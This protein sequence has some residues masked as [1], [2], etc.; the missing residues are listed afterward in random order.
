MVE[1][2]L[3]LHLYRPHDTGS[4]SSIIARTIPSQNG[5]RSQA[6]DLSRMTQSDIFFKDLVPTA[7]E[8]NSGEAN[9]RA[10]GLFRSHS[11]TS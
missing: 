3:G 2:Q 5:M 10:K 1:I 8:N 7:Q 4:K 9:V 11:A 6:R